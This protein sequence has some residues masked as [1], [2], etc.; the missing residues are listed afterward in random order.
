MWRHCCPK[1][2]DWDSDSESL[3]ESEGLSSSDSRGH[4][5]ESLALHVIGLNWSGEKVSLFLKDWELAKGG[6]ELPRC[7]G[8]VGP[9]CA[10]GLVAGLPLPGEPIVTASE[11][12]SLTV[13][14]P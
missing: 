14:R 3:S 5:V 6:I 7:P 4:N 10:S 9:G 11:S 1:S 8:Y 12:L 13:D 2:P